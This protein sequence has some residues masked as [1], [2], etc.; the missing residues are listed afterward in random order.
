VLVAHF[1]VQ[2]LTPY[3]FP[4]VYPELR[5]RLAEEKKWLPGRG[6]RLSMWKEKLIWS[7]D[8][9]FGLVSVCLIV[10]YSDVRTQ[11]GVDTHS[12]WSGTTWSSTVGLS[13]HLAYCT[14]DLFLYVIIGKRYEFWIHHIIVIYCYG[15]TLACDKMHFYAAWIG[16]VEGSNPSL[17]AHIILERIGYPLSHPITLVNGA[18]LW[19]CFLVLRVALI[20]Q[21]LHQLYADVTTNYE[22]SWG[23]VHPGLSYSVVPA[24][25]VIWALSLFWF[26]KVTSGI[27]KGLG[28]MKSSTKDPGMSKDSAR[29]KEY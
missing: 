12:R 11:L 6:R 15:A 9:V 20:P 14:Y 27:L 16:M 19:I 18:G 7:Q 3:V 17:C 4:Q 26:W 24:G 5:A 22:G 2:T 13:V 25:I 1:I 28:V 29:P 10:F 23:V 21:W 8:W